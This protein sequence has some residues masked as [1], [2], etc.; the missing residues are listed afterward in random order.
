MVVGTL[1]GR[2]VEEMVVG[3]F[4]H[5]CHKVS[6]GRRRECYDD[7]CGSVDGAFGGSG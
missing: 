2:L 6:V 1:R 4:K 5:C 7:G 3:A